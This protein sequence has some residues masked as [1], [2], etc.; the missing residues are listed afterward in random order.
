RDGRLKEND[1][2]LAINYTPLDMSVSHQEAI[3]LLQQ[4]SG[5]IH[6]VVAKQPPPLL[7][8]TQ[9]PQ[10]E[11]QIWG[12]VEEIELIND[13]SGLGFGIVGGRASGVIVRTILPG[14]LADR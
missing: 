5:H 9:M 10:K 8:Q 6:L 12:H 3:S 14:G 11:E 4:S 13:G 2:I 1:Q 7:P